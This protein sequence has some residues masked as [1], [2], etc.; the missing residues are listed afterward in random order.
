LNGGYCLTD[1]AAGNIPATTNG[2][3]SASN[4]TLLASPASNSTFN[5]QPYVASAMNPLNLFSTISQGTLKAARRL[6]RRQDNVLALAESNA[7]VIPSNVTEATPETST[8]P[9]TNATASVSNVT[10][11]NTTETNST[12]VSPAN[13]NT[14][15]NTTSTVI[16]LPANLTTFGVLPNAT[17]FR[18]T[19]LPFLFLS[20]NMSSPLL[21]TSCTKSI[22]ASYVAFESRMPYALGLSNSPILGGQGGLYRGI[23]LTC[24]AGFLKSIDDMA[25]QKAALSG[26]SKIIVGGLLPSVGLSFVLGLWLI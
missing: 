25:G 24:G 18:V 20:P 17:T 11:S 26:S 23:G 19:S 21:C 15:S 3:A 14:T 10:L 6:T 16:E 22:L 7:T 12:I 5:F 13:A 1:I 4:V 8:S 2:S 9:V